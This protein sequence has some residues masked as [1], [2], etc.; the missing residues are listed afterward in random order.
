MQIRM[1]YPTKFYFHQRLT[2]FELWLL[3]DIVLL[4]GHFS[5]GLFEKGAVRAM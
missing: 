2:R 1:T 4:D 5:S 3:D